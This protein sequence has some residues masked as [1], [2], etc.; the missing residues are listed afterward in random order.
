M[1]STETLLQRQ[2]LFLKLGKP[3]VTPMLPQ[4]AQFSIRIVG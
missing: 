1:N 3:K 2:L 4:T